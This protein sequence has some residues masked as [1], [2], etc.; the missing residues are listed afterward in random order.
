MKGSD[1][2]NAKGQTYNKPRYDIL[3][4]DSLKTNKT[5]I[6]RESFPRCHPQYN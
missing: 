6:I 5:I 4:E 2:N 1:P 3:T